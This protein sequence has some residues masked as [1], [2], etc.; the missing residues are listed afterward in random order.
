MVKN[1][2]TKYGA[3]QFIIVAIRLDQGMAHGFSSKK[4][5]FLNGYIVLSWRL[6][7]SFECDKPDTKRNLVN[8]VGINSW[9][10][11]IQEVNQDFVSDERVVWL[12]IE[13]VPLYAW[14]R[15]SFDKIGNGTIHKWFHEDVSFNSVGGSG[16]NKG[17]S[18]LG[19]LDEMI[20]VG[21]GLWGAS[22]G[23]GVEKEIES[24]IISKRRGGF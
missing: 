7:G 9:F 15:K 5:G 13:G 17:G 4:E 24:I 18:V 2:C 23:G 16:N 20:R 6:V 14:S 8:H 21:G 22:N 1:L 3:W 10:Q 19:V 11:V 12:D